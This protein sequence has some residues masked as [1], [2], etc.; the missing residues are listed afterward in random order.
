MFKMER[1]LIRIAA[2]LGIISIVL[3]PLLYSVVYYLK[4]TPAMQYFTIGNLIGTFLSLL[5]V[6][7]L[8]IMAKKLDKYNYKTMGV[9]LIIL[10]ILSYWL[11]W[12]PPATLT[13]IAGVMVLRNKSIDNYDSYIGD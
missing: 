4:N 9:L 10:G 12:F 13:I 8:F 6:I 2:V 7:A 1:L 3:V 11:L 5:V